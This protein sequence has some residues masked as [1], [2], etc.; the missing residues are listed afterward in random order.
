MTN[1][2]RIVVFRQVS[3]QSPDPPL[4]KPRQHAG[5]RLK[6]LPHRIAPLFPPAMGCAA[7]EVVPEEQHQVL[8]ATRTHRLEQ[9]GS[10]APRLGTMAR[11]SA[12][13]SSP[14][15]AVNMPIFGLEEF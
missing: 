12:A 5:A 11:N 15:M 4:K 7:V 9:Q 8:A 14:V 10:S 3:T 6:A 1:D 2:L 13:T